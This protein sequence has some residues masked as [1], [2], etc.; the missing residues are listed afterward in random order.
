V[1]K[2]DRFPGE[3]R[4]F[5]PALAAPGI[6]W[7]IV[8]FLVP[9]YSILSV[10]MGRLDPIFSSAEPVWNPVQWDP[11]IFGEVLSDI[12][13]GQLGR[14]FLR[15]IVYVA[16][17]SAL[18]LLIGYPVAYYVARRAGKRKVLLLVLI[19]APFWINYLMRMLA[20]VNLL[21]PDGWVNSG[22]MDLGILDSPR[23]WLVGKHET[24]ILGLVYG[25]VPFL[26]LPL[27]A[28]LD[29]IDSSVLEAARD[30]GA[31]PWRAFVRVTLPLSKQGI[32][33]G[34][35]IVML[36]MFGDYYTPDLLSG[37]PKTRMIGNEI[38]QF[39]NSGVGGARGAALTLVLMTFV[40]FLMA[41]YLFN[42]AQASKAARN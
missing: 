26:I 8:L 23:Q 20:W 29:R 37:S 28:A 42:V 35:V 6:T 38:E 2:G 13:G 31:S 36:P 14:I 11:G 12:T 4:W 32:L 9:F 1:K 18:C 22:L 25:Y 41:Y 16:I 27:Y 3:R 39:I 21:G 10:A 17:A 30:L 34:L 15:T 33:A 7:L 24:V 5:W 40:A 19:L